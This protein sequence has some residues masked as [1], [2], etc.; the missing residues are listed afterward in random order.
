MKFIASLFL[1]TMFLITVCYSQI[2]P[3]KESL[4][5]LYPGKTYSPYA[6]RGYPTQVFW[7][8]SHLHTA[9][10]PDAGLFGNVLGLEEAYRFSRGEEVISSTGLPVRLGRP[11]D[12]VVI[13]DH[14]DMMGF[15]TDLSR[16]APNILSDAKGKEWYEGFQKGGEEA[17]SAALDLITTFAQGKI[18]QKLLADYSPG[19]AT[20]SSVWEDC[21][22]MAE[23]YNDP[24][25]F[26]T[27][28][29]FEWTS[30]NKGNNMHRN[31]IL[32][33]NGNRASQIVPM[34]TQ[35][36]F[37]STDVLEL[38][39]WL[40]NYESKTGGSALAIAHNGNLSNGTMFPFDAQ[41]TGR[42]LDKMYVESRHK[43]EP[44]YEV[45]Q[46]K[47]D[48]E[49]HPFLSPEDAFADYETWDAGN[50]DLSEAK[51]NDMLKHEYAR[52]ALKM[53]LQLESKFG[54]N[55]Y[56]FGMVG[57]T[58]SHTSLSAIEEDNFFGKAAN[59]EPSTKRM[60]HPFAKTDKGAYE[61]YELTASGRAAVWA[62]ENTREAIWD[63]MERKEVYATTGTRMIVRFFGGWDYTNDDINS[64]QPATRGYEKG[65]PMGGDLPAFSGSKSP[66]FMVYA[67]RDPLGANLDRIQIIK[68]WMDKE[69]NTHEKVY[70]VAWSGDRKLN[71]NGELPPVGN[72][73]DLKSA[74]WTNTIGASELGTVWTDPDF[75]PDMEAFYYVR[76]LEIPTPRWVVYDAFRFGI[77]IPEGAK[78]IQQE[79]AYT[80]PIWY[81][82]E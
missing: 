76:V 46:I 18:S 82:P 59:A 77:D 78:T 35:A 29:G 52:E 79:R 21:I 64:R 71:K 61:G 63:A 54:T 81:N 56:K 45:T 31:V 57:S 49:A 53:G 23:K 12:W 62:S 58:D 20:Y 75:D 80:S 15:A 2:H 13:A 73:V 70:N 11:L 6:Q 43:W 16:G 10:S 51:T 17:A 74:N 39:K 28:I 8:D 48:G 32:R 5:G 72:T 34:V 1:S 27:L 7:G 41:F 69:G 38:Y 67:L 19:S 3:S 33:D 40:E 14:S 9:L 25:K 66:T 44:L 60:I 26:T 42:K 22:E 50:L 65:V 4:S 30:L 36:P 55:P 24:G 68:G 47:G 37:G